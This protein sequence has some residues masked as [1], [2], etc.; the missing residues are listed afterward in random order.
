MEE[1]TSSSF[2]IYNVEVELAVSYL[3]GILQ[4]LMLMS[5]LTL[6]YSSKSEIFDKLT[7]NSSVLS[8]SESSTF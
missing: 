8:I 4:L 6:D 7:H 2:K 1:E 3:V 5:Q